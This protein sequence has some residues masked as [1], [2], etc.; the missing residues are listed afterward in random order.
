L[1]LVADAGHRFDRFARFLRGLHDAI[2]AT[3]GFVLHYF[4]AVFFHVVFVSFVFFCCLL[5][6][7]F[8]WCVFEEGLSDDGCV[9]FVDEEGVNR[10]FFWDGYV[11]NGLVC[12]DAGNRVVGVDVVAFFDLPFDEVCFGDAFSWVW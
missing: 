12:F 2:V 3:T 11:D 5:T 10:G 6:V 9:A 8:S 1:G 7:L 4:L